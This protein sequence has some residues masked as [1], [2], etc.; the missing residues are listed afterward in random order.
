MNNFPDMTEAQRQELI[1]ESQREIERMTRILETGSVASG[2]AKAYKGEILRHEILI[3]AL[4][5]DNSNLAR[6]ITARLVDVGS[7][8]PEVVSSS[9]AWV[10][11]KLNGVKS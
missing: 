1:E 9:E 3:A 11:K 4:T 5:R 6:E 8:D 10:L 2:W 7:A